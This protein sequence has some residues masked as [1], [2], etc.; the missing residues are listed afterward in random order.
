[1]EGPRDKAVT[2]VTAPASTDAPPLPGGFEDYDSLSY[3][4]GLT[5]DR[6]RIAEA[7]ATGKALEE[8]GLPVS[9][10]SLGRLDETS[11]GGLLMTMMMAT[12]IC[13]LSLGVLNQPGVERGK[14]LTYR[15]LGRPG[16]GDR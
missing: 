5:V 12:V 13:G 14:I 15:A 1:M 3:L 6:L 8:R 7:E 2:I 11:F 4:Q 10:I 9:Y 16:Y